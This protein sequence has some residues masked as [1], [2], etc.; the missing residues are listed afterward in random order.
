MRTV[1][2]FGEL[3]QHAGHAKLWAALMES[4]P[5]ASYKDI[6]EATGLKLNT[7]KNYRA[8]LV[9]ELSIHGL[10]DPSLAEMR[11]FAVRCRPFLQPH[12]TRVLERS[13]GP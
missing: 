7:V 1:E 4:P 11:D 13:S 8:Q 5:N 2:R 6:A 9:G 3:V 12:V 10:D